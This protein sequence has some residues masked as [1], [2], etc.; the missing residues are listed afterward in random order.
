MK[1]TR[2]QA[3]WLNWI[4]NNGLPPFLRDSKILMQ[5]LFWLMFG[6]KSNLFLEFR[7]KSY[8][9]SDEEY[10]Q[11][12]QETEALNLLK[13]TDLNNACFNRICSEVVGNT[14]LEVGCGRGALLLKL[15][16]QYEVTGCDIMIT[17]EMQDAKFNVV[18]AKCE[19]LP[20]S[21][22]TFDTVIC[23]HV[24]EHVTNLPLALAELKRVC[25]KKLIIV[26]PCERPYKFAFNLHLS[27]FPYKF[28]VIQAFASKNRDS[29]IVCEK[30]DGDWYY[31]EEFFS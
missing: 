27:F 28:N 26:M 20:F 18:T 31:S 16:E 21:D 1:F 17:K 15:A 9:L 7:A 14:I 3:V 13:T 24:L 30:L 6:K 5:P 11:I 4:I 22:N 8:Q 12:Y 19:Q 2:K 25:K 29:E 10:A 23:T